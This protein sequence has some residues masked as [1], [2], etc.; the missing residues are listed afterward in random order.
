MIRRLLFSILVALPVAAVA[1]SAG[2]QSLTMQSSKGTAFGRYS[3]R[4]ADP[5]RAQDPKMWQG[6][7]TIS[8]G[9]ASCNAELSLVTSVYAASGQDF[10]IVLT[11]SGSSAIAHFV[12]LQ[13]CAEKWSPL[14][15]PSAAVKVAGYRLSFLPACEG[16]GSNAPANCSA[17]RVY[18]VH[19]NEPPSYLRSASYKLTEKELGVGFIGE[20][21]VIDPHTPRAMIV[22]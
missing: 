18:L 6:P 19:Q 3:L 4:L 1:Q 2:F 16:G 9:S 17:A 12:E 8:S 11:S 14:K 21:K 13:S 7:L 15:T 5:D 20:A 22:K 10:V